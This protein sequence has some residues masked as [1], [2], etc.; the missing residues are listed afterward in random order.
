[1][2]ML[3]T[4]MDNGGSYRVQGVHHIT[5]IIGHHRKPSPRSQLLRKA[6]TD[7]MSLCRNSHG[8]EYMFVWE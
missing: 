6:R 5:T 4:M 7:R 2:K 8:V 3:Q 1:M